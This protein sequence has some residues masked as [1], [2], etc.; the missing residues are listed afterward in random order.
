VLLPCFLWP[1]IYLSL[2]RYQQP[3]RLLAV[4]LD[5][6]V[7]GAM[8]AWPDACHAACG[9]LVLLKHDLPGVS[10]EAHSLS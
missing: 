10:S 4:M 6:G 5:Q 1:Q 8:A 9:C 3:T 2:T 7:G